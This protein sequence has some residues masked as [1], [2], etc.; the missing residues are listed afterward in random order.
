VSRLSASAKGA[1][2]DFYVS[3]ITDEPYSLLPDFEIVI[4]DRAQVR[5]SKN[6]P[7]GLQQSADM[8]TGTA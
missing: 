1:H 8:D 7:R 2:S 5:N 4:A 3:T 6:V